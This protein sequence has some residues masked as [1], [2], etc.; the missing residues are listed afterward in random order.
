MKPTHRHQKQFKRYL[1]TAAGAVIS[2]LAVNCF[3]TNHHLLSGGVSGISLILHYAF[4]LPIGLMFGLL[5]LPLLYLAYRYLSLDFVLINLFGM[6]CFSLSIDM[7]R[8]LAALNLVDDILLAALVGG[9]A[10]GI[11]N[12]L[13]FREDGGAGGLD[14][15][16]NIV[17][18]YYSLNLG[19]VIFG[20][21]LLIVSAGAFLFGLKPAIYTMISVYIGS[22]VMDRIVDGFNSKKTIT[23]ISDQY[24]EIADA[25]LEEVGRG[26]TILHGEG[27]YTKEKKQVLFIIVTLL[28]IAR[29]KR[30]VAEIDPA[31][32]VIIQDA[33]EV[34]GKGFSFTAV[35]HR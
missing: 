21:N 9:F 17:K 10:N 15:V 27:A 26:V 19:S 28:Q 8:H 2:G 34:S 33:N 32:F 14:I 12:G 31:A 7:T 1:F 29:V 18:K 16:A 5:N 24:A 25:I 30:L 35:P 23:I 20:L 3:I 4:S 13:I 22:Q 6:L 11:G